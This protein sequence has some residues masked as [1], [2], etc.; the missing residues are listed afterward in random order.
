[1][2][3]E[4]LANAGAR[5]VVMPP[6]VGGVKEVQT[7]LRL[8]KY[9]EATASIEAAIAIWQRASGGLS[10][11]QTSRFD[12]GELVRSWAIRG[13]LFVSTNLRSMPWARFDD[14]LHRGLSAAGRSGE[15][16]HQTLPLDHRSGPGDPDYLPQFMR[17]AREY[18]HFYG[19]TS[20]LNA[21][22]AQSVRGLISPTARW[23][24]RPEVASRSG[25]SRPTG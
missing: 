5:V 10:T 8:G 11:V 18:E 21:A 22:A 3:T 6:S 25:R 16:D 13:T 15:L 23:S 24:E 2:W 1:M 7:Y 9:D 19:D 12:R 14:H 20:A 17:L 4:A